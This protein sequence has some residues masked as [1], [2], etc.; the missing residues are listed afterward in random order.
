[1]AQGFDPGVIMG[2]VVGAAVGVLLLVLVVTAIGCY[3][4]KE[5]THHTYSTQV[6]TSML[7]DKFAC[8]VL[9]VCVV[10]MNDN[11]TRHF[12]ENAL[13]FSGYRFTI[14]CDLRCFIA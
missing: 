4:W 13:S 7:E 9:Y 1:M 2:I 3:V 6:R 8:M 10:E 11:F 5:Y 14:I 12:L